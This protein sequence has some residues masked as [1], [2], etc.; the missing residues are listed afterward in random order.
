MSPSRISDSGPCSVACS[1]LITLLG[2]AVGRLRRPSEDR[3]LIAL[4]ILRSTAP[5]NDRFIKGPELSGCSI[6][7]GLLDHIAVQPHQT[8][9]A[10]LVE[11]DEIAAGPQEIAK[12][13]EAQG[14]LAERR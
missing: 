2:L 10:G 5:V 4:R 6:I 8:R 9:G 11:V 7:V 3:P 14:L 12:R 13:L 1:E